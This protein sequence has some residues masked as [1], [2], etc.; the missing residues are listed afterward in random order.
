M[1]TSPPNPDHA[2]SHNTDGYCVFLSRSGR[3]GSRQTD[4]ALDVA[5]GAARL[6]DPGLGGQPPWRTGQKLIFSSTVG[7]VSPSPK[8][9]A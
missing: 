4:I 1:L 9:A 5:Q 7:N 3:S 2:P 6:D 8:V